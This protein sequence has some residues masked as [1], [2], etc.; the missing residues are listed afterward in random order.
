MFARMI[1]VGIILGVYVWRDMYITKI[2]R[3][4]LK[5]RMVAWTNSLQRNLLKSCMYWIKYAWVT[6]FFSSFLLVLRLIFFYKLSSM[7]AASEGCLNDA[8]GTLGA[9]GVDARRDGGVSSD[10]RVGDDEAFRSSWNA[11]FGDSSGKKIKVYRYLK[12]EFC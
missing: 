4:M 7:G 9:G 11:K 6:I 8:G 10:P 1:I 3:W 2:K 12:L 5:M